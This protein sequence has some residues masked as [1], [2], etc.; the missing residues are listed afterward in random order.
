M[1]IFNHGN[2]PG[3][4][5]RDKIRNKIDSSQKN[6][7]E[8]LNYSENRSKF[9]SKQLNSFKKGK[10]LLILLPPKQALHITSLKFK[11]LLL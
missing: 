4:E 9:R 1:V 8:T 5:M 3:K 2:D 11:I 10:T 7:R 6:D